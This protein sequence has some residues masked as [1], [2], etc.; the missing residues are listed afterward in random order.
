[1]VV[2]LLLLPRSRHVTCQRQQS[3]SNTLC[4]C[5]ARDLLYQLEKVVVV[6]RGLMGLGIFQYCTAVTRTLEVFEAVQ[7]NLDSS[8]ADMYA[9][10]VL[11]LQE[12]NERNVPL[13]GPVTVSSAQASSSYD[14]CWGRRPRSHQ[15]AKFPLACR[16]ARCLHLIAHQSCSC[17]ASCLHPT[18]RRNLVVL[19]LDEHLSRA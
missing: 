17:L 15:A 2:M 5:T 11:S 19:A 10:S 12:M 7:P 9:D 18:I 3:T 4:C 16:F 6:I 14:S 1:M 8:Y 13:Q